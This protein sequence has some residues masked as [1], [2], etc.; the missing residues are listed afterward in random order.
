MSNSWPEAWSFD[1]N[2]VAA[3][4]DDSDNDLLSETTQLLSKP[5]AV[6][7]SNS[8]DDLSELP[9]SAVTASRNTILGMIA[10]AVGTGLICTGGSLVV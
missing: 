3:T 1:D 7:I 2:A 9:Q 5:P 10:V 4:I 8:P 6:H